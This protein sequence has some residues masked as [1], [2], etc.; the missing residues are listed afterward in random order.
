VIG[1]TDA[2]ERI[3][4]TAKSFSVGERSVT[5]LWNVFQS[6]LYDLCESQPL[7]GAFLSLFESLEEWETS[8]QANRNIAEASVYAQAALLAEER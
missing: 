3:R 5:E 1:P 6:N 7:Q 4:E 2:A 8:T